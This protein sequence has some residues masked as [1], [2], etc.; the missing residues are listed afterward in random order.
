GS[1]GGG[2]TG[3]YVSLQWKRIQT[4]VANN[5]SRIR[6]TFRLHT[7]YRINFS[8]S[9]SG[10]LDGTSFTYSSGAS[11][12][13]SW[14][15]QTKEIWVN[16]NSD[17]SKSQSFSA[18]F[19]IAITWRGSRVNTLSVS[20]TAKLNTIPRA[21]TLSAFSFNANLKNGVANQINYT[22]DRKS[23]GFRHEIQLR[24]GSTTVKKWDNISSDGKATLSLTASDVNTLLKRMSKS[25]TKSYTLRVATRSGVN[26]GWIGSAVSR[27]A[28]ATVH[29]DVKPT[30][31][32]VTLSQTGNPVSTHTLQGFS[33]IKASF[34]RSAGYGATISS[35]SI[36]VRRRSGGADSQTI[37]SNSGTTSKAVSLHAGYE[38]RG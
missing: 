32:A 17:G 9:K 12:T 31:S 34:T 2:S 15:L 27:N 7:S 38:A 8:T 14:V 3:P 22:I 33:K 19:N 29:A 4:D 36:Q 1:R 25:T 23:S 6:L 30:V 5:R 20:G 10:T 24:D 26:G 35:S 21:S 11:G 16:H 18:S 37:K 13:G 28:T